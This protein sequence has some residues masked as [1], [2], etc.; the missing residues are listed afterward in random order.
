MKSFFGTLK[1]EFCDR[2]LFKSRQEAK[3]EIFEYMEVFY[4]RQRLHFSLGYFPLKF[5]KVSRIIRVLTFHNWCKVTLRMYL[6]L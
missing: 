6:V 2:K 4:N 5:L 3:T 1:V